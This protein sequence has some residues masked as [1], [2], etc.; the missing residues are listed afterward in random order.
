MA[1]TVYGNWLPTISFY[2]IIV[3][4]KRHVPPILEL[5]KV[6]ITLYMLL[7][8]YLGIDERVD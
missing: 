8:D 7:S 6:K 3:I 5:D 2:R 1:P 4:A